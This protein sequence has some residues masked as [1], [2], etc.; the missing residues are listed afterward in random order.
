[1]DKRY[2][3]MAKKANGKIR[4]IKEGPRR[5]FKRVKGYMETLKLIAAL[6]QKNLDTKEVAA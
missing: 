5:K 4:E 6:Q 3:K 2:H 1:M